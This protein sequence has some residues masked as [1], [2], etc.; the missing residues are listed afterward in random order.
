MQL[1]NKG[2]RLHIGI[3]GSCNSGKSTLLNAICG[4]DVAM[5]SDKA[6]TTTDPVYKAME[7]RGVGAVTFID[8]AG[9]DDNTELGIKRIG[10]T[11]KVIDK[12]DIIILVVNGLI[13]DV[14]NHYIELIKS[15]SIELIVVE[16]YRNISNGLN[17]DIAVNAVKGENIDSLLKLIADKS[18]KGDTQSLNL[19]DG[20][21]DESDIVI[22]VMPQDEA[23]PKGRL[24]LPQVQT[25]RELLDKKCVVI[26]VVV[27]GYSV[28]LQM[29]NKTPKLVICDSQVFKEVDNMTP[30]D[31]DLTS[32]SIIL[33][34]QKGDIGVFINGAAAIDELN[35]ESRVLIAE[36]CTHAPIGE[37]IGRVKIPAML[38]KRYGVTDI[39]I[40]AGEDFPNSLV[41]YDLVIHCGACMFNRRLVMNRINIAIKDHCPI[42]NYGVA[43]AKLSGILDR[44]KL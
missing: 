24:I 34:K 8:T 38:F 30:Q 26:S 6:G 5:V 33:A 2:N 23:A 22:L 20:Y 40:V 25:I 18:I 41:D 1:V 44:C 15:R 32:F 17:A 28:A 11:N 36:A 12:C 29:L 43:I 16:N 4:Q 9:Y 37:D 35:P 19:L 14:D 21:V 10:S 39:T 42:T 31:I 13:S 3:L 27:E 7:V